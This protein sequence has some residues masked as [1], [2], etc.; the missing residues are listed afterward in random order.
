MSGCS[1]SSHFKT[2]GSLTLR[3]LMF[4]VAILRL[5]LG[6]AGLLQQRVELWLTAA[7]ID[8][9]V[10]RLAAAA[11]REHRAPEALGR[12]SVEHA[13]FLERGERIGREHL[14]PLVAV[15]ARRVA[16]AEDVTERV[17]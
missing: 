11:R 3:L 5:A 9:R 14:G 12:G 16:A 10:E 7:E 15:V 2:W 6:D 4:Q 13:G 8:E 17:R 1:R